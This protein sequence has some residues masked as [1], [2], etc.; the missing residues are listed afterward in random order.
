MP[1][2]C[3]L[4]AIVGV[5]GLSACGDSAATSAPTSSTVSPSYS[6][7]PPA[8]VS[9]GL[10]EVQRMAAA[11]QATL[12]TDQKAATADLEKMYTTWYEFEGTIRANDKDLY[13][14]MEDGLGS[15]KLGVQEN[16]PDRI[17]SGMVDLTA[18][19]TAYLAA[20]S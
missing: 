16:R 20:N 3:C 19:A 10:A 2:R 5:L 13:L 18:G 14:Q 17:T 6:I 7:V 8:K 12:A 1:Y 15:I 4:A 9:A 11:L